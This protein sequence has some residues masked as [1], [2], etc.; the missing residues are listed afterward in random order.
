MKWKENKSRE[1]ETS[2]GYCEEDFLKKL[3]KSRAG[4]RACRQGWLRMNLAL[5]HKS[6]GDCYGRGIKGPEVTKYII[7]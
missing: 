4:F 5:K 7:Q 3:Y 1:C 6:A 2:L